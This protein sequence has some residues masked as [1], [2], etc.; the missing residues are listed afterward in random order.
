M[1]KLDVCLLF[2]ITGNFRK[3]LTLLQNITQTFKV[4]MVNEETKKHILEKGLLMLA[5]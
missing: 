4:G 2:N 1:K 3:I 5:F